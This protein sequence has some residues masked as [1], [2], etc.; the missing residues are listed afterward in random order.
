M[1]T[2]EQ[3]AHEKRVRDVLNRARHEVGVRDLV[4]F[5]LG[6]M[7]KVLLSLGAVVYALFA[8][9]DARPNSKQS[10]TTDRKEPQ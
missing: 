7:W 10:D 4:T 5:S 8:K 1:S 6:G 9:R 3:L 2:A